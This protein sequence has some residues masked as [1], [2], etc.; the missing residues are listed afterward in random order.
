M[1]KVKKRQRELEQRKEET[2]AVIT[3][4]PELIAPGDVTFLAHALVVPSS[5]PED[6]MR[7]DADIEARAV[8]VA[9]AFEEALGASV[10]DVSKAEQ[11]V[12]AGLEE[13][14]GFDL[15]STRPNGEKIA[16]EVKGRA[17]SGDVELSENEFVKACNLR[18]RY[19]LYV[20]YECAKASPRLWRI[21]D[22]FKKLIYREK[23]RVIVAEDSI[24]AAAEMD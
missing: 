3:R 23:K 11:A 5:D 21:Q 2:L 18:E 16:I 20:V 10:Q 17:A 1:T 9:I 12:A 15:L 4:E 24:F 13:W 14:P 6:K 22:P 7:Y 19:W 8:Q